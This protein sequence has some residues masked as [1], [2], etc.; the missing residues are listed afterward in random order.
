MKYKLHYFIFIIII[1]YL[2]S[3]I[4]LWTLILG[5]DRNY[6]TKMYLNINYAGNL[7]CSSWLAHS[8]WSPLVI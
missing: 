4:Y 1:L 6:Q 8:V 3:G 7:L 5:E 2:M